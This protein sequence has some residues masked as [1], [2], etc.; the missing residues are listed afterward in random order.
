MRGK[1]THFWPLTLSCFAIRCASLCLQSIYKEKDKIDKEIRDNIPGYKDMKEFE[2][3]FK[4]R[5]KEKP[6]SWLLT[7]GIYEL[8]PES[9]IPKGPLAG[10]KQSFDNIFGKK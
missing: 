4:I 3:G 2:Y 7:D 10:V 1:C 5:D 9:E 6:G 8:P